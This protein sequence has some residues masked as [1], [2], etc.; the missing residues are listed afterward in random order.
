MHKR[1]PDFL[2]SS[3]KPNHQQVLN[4]LDCCNFI[5]LKRK[6]NKS[7]AHE[8]ASVRIIHAYIDQ[9]PLEKFSAMWPI[10]Y[11]ETLLSGFFLHLNWHEPCPNPYYHFVALVFLHNMLHGE[12]PDGLLGR[13]SSKPML[14]SESF[15]LMRMGIPRRTHAA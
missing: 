2:R 14:F 11:S 8:R 7:I 12:Y 3:P 13:F 4:G 6:R 15:S 9:Q 5:L 10:I 1:T